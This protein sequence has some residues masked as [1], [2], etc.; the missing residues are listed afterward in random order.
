MGVH[1]LTRTA[2]RITSAAPIDVVWPRFVAAVESYLLRDRVG[3]LLAWN[4]KAS[5]CTK[6]FELTEVKRK[7]LNMPCGIQYFGDH[8]TAIS[9]Y[10]TNLYNNKRQTDGIP[11]GYG[12]GMMYEIIF[13]EELEDAY[14]AIVDAK[15]HVA[16]FSFVPV[17]ETFD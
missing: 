2:P 10:K 11:E 5:D 9:G 16:I 7:D 3:M 8:M 4:G 17:Q 1:G 12:L 15:A 6:L 13:G 14:D